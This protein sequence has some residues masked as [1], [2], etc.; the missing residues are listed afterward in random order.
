ML[1]TLFLL[2]SKMLFGRRFGPGRIL[3]P[4][5]VTVLLVTLNREGWELL[6]RETSARERGGLTREKDKGV[7]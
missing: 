4:P 1:P 5:P 2:N 6:R 3:G 7:T